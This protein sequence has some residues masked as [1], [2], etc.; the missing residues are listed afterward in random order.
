METR[1]N[2]ELGYGQLKL[3]LYR[4][5][6]KYSRDVTVAKVITKEFLG[7]VHSPIHTDEDIIPRERKLCYQQYQ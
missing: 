3:E 7:Y 1:V 2:E 5:N 6:S 4:F